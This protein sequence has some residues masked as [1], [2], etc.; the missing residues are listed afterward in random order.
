M[1]G[2]FAEI[3]D[4]GTDPFEDLYRPEADLRLSPVIS[5]KGFLYPDSPRPRPIAKADGWVL[6]GY[7]RVI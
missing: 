7:H 6:S 2:L 3:A 4:N 5:V 1:N